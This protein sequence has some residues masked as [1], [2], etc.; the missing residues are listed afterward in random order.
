[1]QF[2]KKMKKVLSTALSIF[3]MLSVVIQTSIVYAEEGKT[4]SEYYLSDL[5]WVSASHG[6]YDTTKEVQ[7]DHPFTPGNNGEDTKI[8]LA[9]EDGATRTFEK[10]LGTVAASPSSIV[11]NITGAEVTSFSCYLGI[12]RTANHSLEKHAMVEKVEITAD[13]E[14]LYSSIDDYPN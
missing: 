5:K 11:Y 4:G 12:D 6:D 1:M 8:S 9:M 2:G 3:L 13:D 10:G 14:I 7:K